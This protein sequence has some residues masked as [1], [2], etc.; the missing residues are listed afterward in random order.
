MNRR[1][2]TWP[3]SVTSREI[4]EARGIWDA[5]VR[6][7]ATAKE[8]VADEMDILE[9]EKD[10]DVLSHDVELHCTKTNFFMQ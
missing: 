8:V 9:I 4:R 10:C 6:L 2:R 5:P 1:S 7:P 3:S